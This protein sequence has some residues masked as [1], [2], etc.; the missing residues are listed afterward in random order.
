MRISYLK[1]MA[2]LAILTAPMLL[3]GCSSIARGVTEAVINQEEVKDTRQCEIEG[4]AFDGIRQSF[5]EQAPSTPK[6]TKILMVHGVSSHLPGYS[7]RFQKKLFE[8]LGLDIVDSTVKTITLDSNKIQWADDQPHTL[9]TL[10]ISRHTDAQNAR[11][12]IFYELTWSSITDPQKKAIMADSANYEGLPRASIN[13]SL[14]N[15]MNETVPDLLIYN[16]NGYERVTESV[17]QA[18]CWMLGNDWDKLPQDGVHQCRQWPHSTYANMMRDDHYFVTHS[19]GSRIAID[20]IHDL[21]AL[22]GTVKKGPDDAK[23]SK[24]AQDKEFTVFMLANQLPLL[25]AG[26]SMPAVAGQEKAYC[27]VGGDKTDDRVLRRMNIIAFSDPNDILSYPVAS[28]YA[29][30]NID[31]RICPAVTNISLNIAHE[32]SIFDTANF[33]NPVSAHNG[34]ME[35]DRV[36]DLIANG[37]RRSDAALVGGK[38]RWLETKKL[39]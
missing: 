27:E 20:T 6:V 1:Y 11:Q 31:S 7:S 30:S 9:G 36:I 26:R 33:A 12:L 15:L 23:R 17:S 16:G 10:K 4:P 28:D 39:P 18:V 35:D 8:D 29:T 38:C 37:I 5:D 34:Y 14:K 2:S 24:A 13:K 19:L 32:R 3:G 22:N 25:Q 21:V